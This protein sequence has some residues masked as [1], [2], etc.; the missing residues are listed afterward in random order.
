MQKA[1]LP[2]GCGARASCKKFVWPFTLEVRPMPH[3]GWLR[4]SAAGQNESHSDH[5]TIKS[6]FLT[7]WEAFSKLSLLVKMVGLL[8]NF[9]AAFCLPPIVIIF[10]SYIK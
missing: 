3:R 5:P 10:N 6:Q 8:V 7:R 1:R 2:S 9:I 4:H